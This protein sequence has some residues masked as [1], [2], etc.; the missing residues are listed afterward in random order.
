MTKNRLRKIT[1]DDETYLWKRR[2]IHLTRCDH[3]KCVEKVVIY[4]EGYKNSPLQLL[5]REEDS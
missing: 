5:F 3:S 4:F 1:I 2:H